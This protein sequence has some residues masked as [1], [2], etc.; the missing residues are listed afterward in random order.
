MSE[1]LTLNELRQARD[2]I[3]ANILSAKP[4]STV[5]R[6]GWYAGQFTAYCL[7]QQ[8][9]RHHEK[10]R[11]SPPGDPNPIMTLLVKKR[12]KPKGVI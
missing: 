4:T 3:V 1:V 9:I 5:L 7:L 6:S 12:R 11:V 8:E 2:Q 10:P